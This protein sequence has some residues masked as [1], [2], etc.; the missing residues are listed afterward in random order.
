MKVKILIEWKL[1]I[2][3]G[4]QLSLAAEASKQNGEDTRNFDTTLT[5]HLCDFP[6]NKVTSIS[7]RT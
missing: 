2:T 3:A 6:P 4:I 1:Q 5:G 7:K